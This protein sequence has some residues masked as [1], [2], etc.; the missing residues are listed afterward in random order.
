MPILIK[1]TCV[2]VVLVSVLPS[3]FTR[4]T[5][6]ELSLQTVLIAGMVAVAIV[7]FLALSLIANRV[8]RL[9]GA[10]IFSISAA[11]TFGYYDVYEQQLNYFTFLG[12]L[13]ERGSAGFA[14]AM[15]FTSVIF[16]LSGSVVTALAIGL[17]PPII[18]RLPQNFLIALPLMAF[19]MLAC[20][21]ISRGGVNFRGVVHG[22]QGLIYT[23]RVGIDYF[24]PF[25]D[26]RE[27]VSIERGEKPVARDIVLIVDE[28][29]PGQYLDINS[30]SGV[31][32]GLAK[33]R[34]GVSIHNFGLATSITNCSLGSN[35][36]LRFGGTRQSIQEKIARAP[37]LFDYAETAGMHTSYLYSYA[38]FEDYFDGIEMY[39]IQSPFSFESENLIDRDVA[40]A[41]EL[42]KLLTNNRSDFVYVNKMGAHFSV[43]KSYPE[44]RTKYR[45]ALSRNRIWDLRGDD[46][47]LFPGMI[48]G[49]DDWRLY[50]NAFRNTFEWN[51]GYY[52]DLALQASE[53]D[54]ATIIYTSDHGQNLH[55]RPNDAKGTHCAST[56]PQIE[57]GVVPL[58]IIEFGKTTSIDW[59][60]AAARN[61][62]KMSHF[63]IFPTLLELMGYDL[64]Q[65]KN[66]YG[67][68]L[69]SDERDEYTF[70]IALYP[71]QRQTIKWKKVDADAVIEPFE[72]DYLPVENDD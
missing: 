41:R 60:E 23:T 27:S 65:V 43:N 59:T 53:R 7:G 66:E 55:E 51:V 31:Y 62:N 13:D 48:T 57:E 44:P 29:I 45:P 8:I 71:D 49:P 39:K 63:R 2:T 61:H 50:R 42:Q 40:S 16:A 1:L 17:P 9:V 18:R 28:S 54:D 24:W 37:S 67:P 68:G 20:A 70:A 58:V 34:K 35:M 33:V 26:M 32:S 69:R 72:D 64:R 3:S 12:L 11:L 56:D 14:A 47:V 10:S 4:L 52:F 22:W 46:K 21:D 30:E 15:Y 5:Q 25:G 19:G 36:G 6:I 38:G